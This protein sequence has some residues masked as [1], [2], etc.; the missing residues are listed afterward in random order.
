MGVAAGG[1]F[2][3]FKGM[4]LGQEAKPGIPLVQGERAP[5]TQELALWDQAMRLANRV[6][7]LSYIVKLQWTNIKMIHE[8]AKA[9]E[10]ALGEPDLPDL[11]ERMFSALKRIESLK[12]L[13]CRVNQ[14]E[15]GISMSSNGK[16]LDIVEPQ[17]TTNLSFGWVIPLIGAALVV[18]GIIGIWKELN[19]ECEEIT[20]RYNAIIEKADKSLCKDPSSTLCNDWKADK[21]SKGY[22]KRESIID[23][24]KN[25]LVSAGKTAKTGLGWGI[26][27]LIPLLGLM[28]LP[29]RKG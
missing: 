23:S 21:K 4:M 20:D 18:A 28:Y 13:M 5:T 2:R 8:F 6:N 27:L 19:T 25:A 10:V 26:A 16:D 17:E 12:D 22:H 14:L 1:T 15:L 9:N 29:R 11:A 7:L 24:V 3:Q